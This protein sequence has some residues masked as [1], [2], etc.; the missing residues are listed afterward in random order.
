MLQVQAWTRLEL[1]DFLRGFA[2][3]LMLIYH[4]F[5]DLDYFGKISLQSS[6]WYFFPRFIGGTFIFVAGISLSLAK[7]KYGERLTRESVKRGAK[8]LFLGLI[9]TAIT[10]PTSCYVR[11]GI[12][13]FFGLAVILGSF[14]AG[15]RK[16]SAAAGI[17][18]FLA[19]LGL[20]QMAIN[21]EYL[22]WLGVMPAGFCTLDYYP[23]LPWLGV[24]LVGIFVG[25]QFD[26][27]FKLPDLLKPVNFLGRKSLTIYMIQHPLILIIMQLYYGDIIDHIMAML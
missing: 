22:V 27:T 20:N 18:L 2:V 23:L 21:G 11:F 15:Y 8:Y 25:N 1:I 17:L 26:L 24:M 9:I 19:G 3:I 6:F 12:L 4:F 16:L 5:F 10:L 14:F 7:I 13:H